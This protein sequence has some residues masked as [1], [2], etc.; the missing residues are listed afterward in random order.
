[1]FN[2]TLCGTPCVPTKIVNA[3][4]HLWLCLG[5]NYCVYENLHVS[6]CKSLCRLP[7][8]IAQFPR[9]AAASIPDYCNLWKGLLPFGCHLILTTQAFCSKAPS[10]Y[11]NRILC[12]LCFL[13]W[14]RLL[15]V[16]A[17]DSHHTFLCFVEI[18][19]RSSSD[20][21]S[22]WLNFKLYKCWLHDLEKF[23]KFS[24]QTSFLSQWSHLC[25][26]DGIDKLQGRC[27]KVIMATSTGA[28][29]SLL[30]EWTNYYS[31]LTT[32]TG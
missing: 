6:D 13:W 29:S 14:W 3:T 7:L 9:L 26:S 31:M 8:L 5:V 18:L 17:D 30:L 22:S 15:R 16:T 19:L 12:R 32:L 11:Q 4:L 10:K 2:F 24:L 25:F 27:V 28:Y 21:D 23:F 1:M 20:M